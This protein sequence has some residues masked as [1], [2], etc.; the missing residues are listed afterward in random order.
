MKAMILAAGKGERMLPLT[1]TC[2]KPLLQAGG[3]PLLEH[4]LQKLEA[5]GVRDIVINTAYLGEQIEAYIQARKSLASITISQESEPL[6]TG[7]AL[8]LALPMLGRAPFL[9]VNGDV[10][11]D[12]DLSQM[13]A[14]AQV[15]TAGAY[16]VMV[17][18]P[19]HNPEGDF[20]L[21]GEGCVY[22]KQMAAEQ[23]GA[24]TFSGISVVSPDM[25]R[26]YPECRRKFPLREVFSWGL[27]N[28]T[29]RGEHY[30]G[31]WLDV[32]TP[33]RLAELNQY[34]RETL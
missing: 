30:S 15:A 21:G 9:L 12:I 2:P 11:C 10:F 23:G 32:G 22:D 19:E 26:Q 6:E 28:N 14:R 5:A 33:E 34:L 7:G 25:I 8:H 29:I 20:V 16:F 3:K 18:N 4:W 13:I 24:L 31:Y 1:H 27:N 17:N